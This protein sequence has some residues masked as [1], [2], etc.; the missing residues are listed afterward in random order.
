M[1]FCDTDGSKTSLPGSS[2]MCFQYQFPFNTFFNKNVFFFETSR[3]K[4]HRFI[5]RLHYELQKWN[6]TS[7]DPRTAFHWLRN[8]ISWLKDVKSHCPGTVQGWLISLLSSLCLR[9]VHE[10]RHL[11][12]CHHCA[13]CYSS[14]SLVP[15]EDRLSPVFL[16]ATGCPL[17]LHSCVKWKL[18][19]ELF[20]VS[21]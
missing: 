4:P 13:F 3:L 1:D 6:H 19:K 10:K 8:N 14:Y 2:T 9:L 21:N 12:P 20:V 15:W 7:L 17:F 16:C 11:G 18:T 5:C